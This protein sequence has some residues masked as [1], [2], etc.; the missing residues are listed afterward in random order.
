MRTHG[1][2]ARLSAAKTAILALLLGAPS[3]LVFAQ[4]ELSELPGGMY[5]QYRLAERDQ[6]YDELKA[7][8]S[9]LEHRGAVLRKVIKMVQ[10]SVVHIE[11]DKRP[12]ADF[13]DPEAVIEEAGSG[14]IVEI[15][16]DFFV[17]TNRHV[18][19]NADGI[20]IKLTDGQV[21][22]PVK[23]WADPTT[24]V[25]VLGIVGKNLIPARLGNSDHIDIGDFVL[26]IGSPFGLSHSVTHGIIS[27]KGRRDL[28]LGTD[29]VHIQDFIQTDAAINPGNSGGPLIS[30]RGEV[31][32][33]NT[34]IA[35]NS[36]GN[37][38][39]GFSIPINLAIHV[40]KQLVLEGELRR[41]YL[42]V[43]LDS[44]FQIADAHKLGLPRVVGAKVT[45]VTPDSPADKAE[46]KAEDIV[47]TFN[48]IR[49]EDDAHLVSLV[50]LTPIGAEVP[51]VVYR[52]NQMTT[53]VVTLEERQK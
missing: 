9:A 44:Q 11:A 15:N 29:Q 36:G 13:E 20:R 1:S 30:M 51:M 53:L 37:E 42:G 12:P 50:G 26:A 39:I 4:R 48:G 2:G 34:A 16:G 43:S 17:I 7:T 41:A 8:V 23:Q 10:P 31:V 22:H 18:I 14:I 28:S 47:L 24:D 25:A 6:L 21:L 35:S 46:L 19:S 45:A 3:P 32:G 40:A 52:G 49:V 5:P 27:A 33:I 38:G